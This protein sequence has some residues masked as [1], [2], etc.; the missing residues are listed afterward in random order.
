MSEKEMSTREKILLTTIDCIEKEGIQR[1][2]IRKIAKE[3]AVNSA[4]INYYFGTKEKLMTKAL[5]RTLEEMSKMP[6]EI[7]DQEGQPQ[8]ALLQAFLEVLM[9]GAI[10]WP[11]ITKAHI[12]NPLMLN[13]YDDL[14]VRRFNSFLEDLLD[15]IK[16][17]K[18]KGRKKDSKIVL[19]QILS[20]VLLPAIMPRL[21]SSF[22]QVN[23]EDASIRKTYIAQLLACFFE[24]R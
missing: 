18:L 22:S 19:I 1:V 9:D 15:K 12:Y 4:A 14:F 23:F 24:K 5:E 6:G 13:D 21:F 7:F 10:K 8:Y 3:A 2:T 20:A 16:G 17:V 11:G